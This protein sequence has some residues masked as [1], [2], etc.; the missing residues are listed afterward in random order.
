MLRLP[1][2]QPNDRQRLVAAEK[3]SRAD[4]NLPDEAM[5]YCCFNGMNKITRP[6]F[7]RWMRI[8]AAV[9]GSVLWLLDSAEST[10]DRL[11]DHARL[12]GVAPEKLIFAGRLA[13]PDHVARYA[14]ADLFLDTS[15]YGAHTTA[16][17]ALWAGLPILTYMGRSFA[18]RVCG[19]L[20]HAAGL[21]ELVCESPDQ[22]ERDAIR[23]GLDADLRHG[24]RQ[25]LRMKHDRC[26]LFDTPRLVRALEDLYALM[27][28]EFSCGSLPVPNLV[29][30]SVYTDIACEADHERGDWL[31]PSED[32][33]RTQLQYRH[34]NSPLPPDSRLW[35]S[36]APPL[37]RAA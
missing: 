8:L 16:S 3:P 36:P 30:L 17:D 11:R 22:Y 24:Y 25:R 1:C 6:V 5:V 23:I 32:A 34:A 20:V 15:H 2:Y 26:T 19:S 9:P 28:Q 35:P 27:W 18:A 29:N 31:H 13:T 21:H 33:Y 10:M 14:A 7:E 4:C 37:A 12:C